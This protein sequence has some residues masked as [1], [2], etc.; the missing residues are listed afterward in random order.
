MKPAQ[1]AARLGLGLLVAAVL[2]GTVELLLRALLGPPPPALRVFGVLGPDGEYWQR[3]EEHLHPQ[4]VGPEGGMGEIP[5]APPEPQLLVLGGSSVHGGTEG[6]AATSEFPSILGRHLGIRAWN[7]G[8]PGFD[9]HDLA[10]ILE[11]F[12]DC[13]A[14]TVVVYAGHNDLGNIV[15]H[16]R[17]GTVQAGLLVRAQSL[18]ERL[19]LFTQLSRVLGPVQGRAHTGGDLG[20][21]PTISPERRAAA[22]AD[23][24]RNLERLA[25]LAA[26]QERRLVLVGAVSRLTDPPPDADCAEAHCPGERHSAGMALAGEDPEEAARLLREAWDRSA[27]VLRATSELH[28]L[29]A[30]VAEGNPEHVTWVDAEEALPQHPDIAVPADGLFTDGVH[31]SRAGHRALAGVLTA[32][33]RGAG[34]GADGGRAVEGQAPGPPPRRAP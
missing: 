14:E 1:L 10:R 20:H 15:F 11:G 33:L 2:L 30:Q 27:H 21:L 8:Y 34:R 3:S 22:V 19:Q 25:W 6:L 4:W 32:H 9:S 23:F 18:L 13:R 26:A 16:E 12:G 29:M 5:C 17:Y 7:L 24:G 31:L 28:E